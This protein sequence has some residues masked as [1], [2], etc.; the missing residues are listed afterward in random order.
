MCGVRVLPH[1]SVAHG[2]S[3]PAVQEEVGEPAEEGRPVRGGGHAAVAG[4]RGEAVR[5][6]GAR[7]GQQQRG[8]PPAVGRRRRYAGPRAEGQGPPVRRRWGVAQQPAGVGGDDGHREG[9]GQGNGLSRGGQRLPGM[10][11]ALLKTPRLGAGLL[12][13]GLPKIGL[14]KGIS[15]R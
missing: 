5:H 8:Q 7:A 6:G 15:Q 1:S 13:G 11:Q 12:G 10:G 9:R 3:G 2:G 4:Q 14:P